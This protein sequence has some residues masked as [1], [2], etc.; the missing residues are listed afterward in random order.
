MAFSA[1]INEHLIVTDTVLADGGNNEGPGPNTQGLTMYCGGGTGAMLDHSDQ[2]RGLS[3]SFSK[4]SDAP[5][6]TFFT[7]PSPDYFQYNDLGGPGLEPVGSVSAKGRLTA[8]QAGRRMQELR[9][10]LTGAPP[11]RPR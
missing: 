5:G 11:R 10:V 1:N 8:R 2:Y 6:A 4:K 7:Q 3:Y 9:A